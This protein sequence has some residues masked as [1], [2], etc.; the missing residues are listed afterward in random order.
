MNKVQLI[1]NS[2]AD[3]KL[4]YT[5][6]GTAVCNI[7][8][9][10]SEKSSDGTFTSAW[11]RCTL[12]GKLAESIGPRIKKGSKLF[13]DGKLNPREWTDKAGNKQRSVDV[14]AW[15]VLIIER[16]PKFD[17]PYA[18]GQSTKNPIQSPFSEE[19]IPF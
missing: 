4:E 12:F 7:S 19:D 16:E 2:G 14:I 5:Q 17:S 11:H 15:Q 6:S 3:A 10:T 13:I 18:E 1:G 9:A 8:I